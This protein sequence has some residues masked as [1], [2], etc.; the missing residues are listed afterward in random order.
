MSSI[1]PGGG[2]CAA[3]CALLRRSGGGL[4]PP[5]LTPPRGESPPAPPGRLR[6]FGQQDAPDASSYTDSHR[7][8]RQKQK[9]QLFLAHTTPKGIQY[10]RGRVL[11]NKKL[12]TAP[13]PFGLS[14]KNPRHRRTLR[15]WA[16]QTPA[17]CG[18]EGI[19]QKNDSTKSRVVFCH[20]PNWGKRYSKVVCNVSCCKASC[21]AP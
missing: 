1:A 4:S 7:P 15:K 3:P 8:T 16:V 20:V 21:T 6:R 17:A 13:T 18:G 14:R 10:R 2:L 5:P 9:Q 19:V 11:C 12:H